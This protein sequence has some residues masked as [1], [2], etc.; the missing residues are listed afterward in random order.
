MGGKVIFFD[1]DGT[2]L[3]HNNRLPES[4]KHSIGKLHRAGH[5][6]A[7]ATARPPFRFGNIAQ[8]LGVR[9]YVSMNGQY[10]T[11]DGEV[12]FRAP[13]E[14]EKVSSLKKFADARRHPLVFADPVNTTASIADHDDIAACF[15]GL[16][17]TM[18]NMIR[19]MI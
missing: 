15:A 3:D 18:L 14:R 4:T 10:V 17:E 16:N 9:S 13:L 5:V 2:L 12:I 7:I 19:T 8:E 6:V 11:V 1:I